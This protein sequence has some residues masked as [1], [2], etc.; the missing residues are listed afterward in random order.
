[1]EEHQ[2]S[3]GTRVASTHHLQLRHRATQGPFLAVH[4]R[5]CRTEEKSSGHRGLPRDTN[6]DPAA[7]SLLPPGR[8]FTALP[9]HL[10]WPHE[11]AGGA[12]AARA[13][14]AL[15]DRRSSAGRE[16]RRS[17]GQEGSR[18]QAPR[19]GDPPPARQAHRHPYSIP[20]P[21]ARGTRGA[22]ETRRLFGGHTV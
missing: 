6:K 7:L 12:D 3:R 5:I 4:K 16:E 10:L 14:Q 17:G 13:R 22:P 11:A 1:M 9:S 21:E 18:A 2:I 20:F 19:A 8:R 15:Q